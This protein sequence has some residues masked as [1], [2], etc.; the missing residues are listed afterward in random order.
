MPTSV[1]ITMELLD[2]ENTQTMR[3]LEI[4]LGTIVILCKWRLASRV[5]QVVVTEL[6]RYL[7]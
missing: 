1:E 5:C 2:V 7:S 6:R 3:R 4:R